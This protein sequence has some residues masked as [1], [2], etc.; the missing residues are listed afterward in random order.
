[1]KICAKCCNKLSNGN[2]TGEVRHNTIDPTDD[3][4][5]IVGNVINKPS[6]PIKS[7]KK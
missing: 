3:K 5:H 4:I 2:H 7:L 1:M 6:D